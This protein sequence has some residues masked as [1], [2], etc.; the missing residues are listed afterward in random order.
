MAVNDVI[1]LNGTASAFLSSGEANPALWKNGTATAL[2][3]YLI[4]MQTVTL[5][6]ITSAEAWGNLQ[7]DQ[8]IQLNGI[9]SGEAWGTVQVDQSI[10][11]QGIPSGEAWGTL[12]AVRH[13]MLSGI[14]SAEAWG[15]IVLLSANQV[16][17]SG[18]ESAEAW[19]NI[20]LK[21][22]MIVFLEGIPS[23][24]AWGNLSVSLPYTSAFLRQL[25]TDFEDGF[26]N[27]LEFA[28]PVTLIY[29][30]GTEEEVSAIFDN[31][32]ILV[33]TDG[34][35]SVISRIPVI[36]M[37]ASKYK[38]EIIKGAKVIIQGRRFDVIDH[39][40]DGTG[41]LVLTLHNERTV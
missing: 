33:D 5:N 36:W 23:A 34:G 37:Q 6:G 2:H 32:T 19:G 12:S 30:N 15:D 7:V 18:I 16:I 24:E 21:H 8:E 1:W 40:P 13:I 38:Y 22:T 9:P 39:Q 28:R 11:L 41:L 10:S 14:P 31:E 27:D 25:E 26:M 3:E 20:T 4:T 17:L 35:T 29:P